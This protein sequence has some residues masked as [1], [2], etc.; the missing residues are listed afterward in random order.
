[1]YLNCT[2]M[3]VYSICDSI[4]MLKKYNVN[5]FSQNECKEELY[6]SL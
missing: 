5:T 2:Y 6:I 1:M 4:K 3:C